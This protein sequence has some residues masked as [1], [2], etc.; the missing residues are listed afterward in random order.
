MDNLGLGGSAPASSPI[1]DLA[2]WDSM[3][4]GIQMRLVRRL[5]PV[6]VR[7]QT[8]ICA[9]KNTLLRVWSAPRIRVS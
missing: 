7:T 3:A 1:D 5:H 2:R 4:N 9:S 6:Q 8:P